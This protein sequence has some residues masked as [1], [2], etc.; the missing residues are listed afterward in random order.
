MKNLSERGLIEVLN[1]KVLVDKIPILGVL[2]GLGFIDASTI[3][4][5]ISLKVPHMGW[6][7][8]SLMKDSLLF[9][10]MYTEPRFYFVH[11]YHVVCNDKSDIL[12]ETEYGLKFTSMI[13]R[14][15]IYGAQFHPEKSHKYGMKLLKNFVELI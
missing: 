4:F 1:K 9:K 15:N 13:N 3:K 5:K 11:S 12:T 2:P 10:D 7:Y 6:D 14:D 8:V